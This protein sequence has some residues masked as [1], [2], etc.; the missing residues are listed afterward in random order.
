VPIILNRSAKIADLLKLYRYTRIRDHIL[1][2]AALRDKLQKIPSDFPIALVAR[3]IEHATDIDLVIPGGDIT[4]V[5]T[6]YDGNGR[7]IDVSGRA[8]SPGSHG[9]KGTRGFAADPDTRIPGGPGGPGETGTAGSDGGRIRVVAEQLGDVSLRANGGQGGRGGQGGSG[10]DGG[11]GHAGSTKFDSHQGSV[12]GPGGRAGNGGNGGKGGVIEV[13]FTAAGVPDSPIMTT[14]GGNGGA[15]G[16]TGS[17]GNSGFDAEPKQGAHGAV[18]K[19]GSAGKSGAPDIDVVGKSGFRNMVAKVLGSS[20]TEDWAAYRLVV[21]VY[22]YRRYKPND[23]ARS[24]HLKLAVD[25][26]DAILRLVPGHVEATRYNHQIEQAQNVLG[27]G[28]NFD[29]LP[30]FEIYLAE[31]KS[32]VGFVGSFFKDGLALLLA[33]ANE[34]TVKAQ[35]VSDN[36]A[37]NGRIV[38]SAT[39]RDAAK[40]G[41]EISTKV[42][43]HAAKRLADLN[44]QIIA[45]SAKS[46]DEPI[47]FGSIVSTVG[48]VATAVVAVAGAVGTGGASLAALV[49]AIAGLAAKLNDVGDHLFSATEAD[50]KDV[51]AKYAAVGK[52]FEQVMASAKAGLT[53]TVDFVAAIKKFSSAKSANTE[54]V[55]LMRQGVELAYEVL[56]SNLHN[57]QAE[58]TLQARETEIAVTQAMVKITEARI[59]ATTLDEELLRQSGLAAVRA[60][61]KTIDSLL[62]TAFKAQRAVEIYT[63]HDA[64]GKVS[65]DS[66]FV[67]PDL[68]ADFDEASLDG[69]GTNIRGLSN[70]EKVV[71]IEAL[72]FHTQKLVTS[73]STSWS[74]FIEII[75]LQKIF[76]K[77][78]DNPQLP[79]VDSQLVKTINDT[80]SLDTFKD[81]SGEFSRISFLIDSSDF[82]ADELETKIVDVS[83]ALA[84]VTLTSPGLPCDVIH[85]GVYLSKLRDD[86]VIAQPLTEQ[87]QREL[88]RLELFNQ[89]NPPTFT[90]LNNRL[91]IKT[92]HLWGRGV[93]GTWEISIAESV[94]RQHGVDLT[95]LT[96]IQLWISTQSFVKAS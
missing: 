53:A 19:P 30:D 84:G 81:R 1:I 82:V 55:G 23:Q 62:T 24:G 31:Y 45:A 17:G 85:G 54:V 70:A 86:T 60:T 63:F 43:E 80:E 52:N 93:A 95:G 71:I 44:A 91:L 36:G 57:K 75:D 28:A 33:S 73:Y 83:V 20:S 96:A 76:D 51:K 34:N 5:A 3:H 7:T 35:L 65:F 11:P 15:A 21:G 69:A 13:R 67:H 40:V 2:D 12:G 39:D 56:V 94:L 46:P 9:S 61:Q 32:T 64:S 41:T 59:E 10:G 29:L 37:L 18:G 72:K 88:P 68:E 38:V 42:A 58:L 14:N 92:N 90:G 4:I 50:I 49:P 22:C 66:G 6:R 48:L 78:F 79:F 77:Y 87:R 16:P 47:T 27:F 25:E 26:F 8:G 89:N 74:Q